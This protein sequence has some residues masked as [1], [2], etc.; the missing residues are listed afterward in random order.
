MFFLV[1]AAGMF[2][3]CVPNGPAQ[4]AARDD[5]NIY[6]EGVWSTLDPFGTGCTSYVN[7]NLAS[8]RNR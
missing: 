4:A 3:A 7:M 8:C 6:C 5:V 1:L 2:L